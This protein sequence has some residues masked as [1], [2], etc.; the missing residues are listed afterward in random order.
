M[1]L[2]ESRILL[3]PDLKDL[4]PGF[5]EFI[6]REVKMVHSAIKK[7]DYETVFKL[8]GRMKSFGGIYGFE[9]ITDA[10][11]TIEEAAAAQNAGRAEKSLEALSSYLES[12]EIVYDDE[13]Y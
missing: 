4:I 10:G 1:E 8:G 5:L 2:I 13:N 11:M 9:V 6:E 7:S 12:I 3:N